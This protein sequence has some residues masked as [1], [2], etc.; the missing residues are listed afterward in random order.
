[1]IGHLLRKLTV[2]I[3]LLI[4]I[5]CFIT[6]NEIIYLQDNLLS[7]EIILPVKVFI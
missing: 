1:M 4:K 3:S 5:S 2:V 7:I 6:I